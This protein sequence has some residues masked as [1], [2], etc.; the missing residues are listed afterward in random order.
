MRSAL[1]NRGKHSNVVVT[2]IAR[3][4]VAFLWA[5][6]QEVPIPARPESRSSRVWAEARPRFGATLDGV[7]RRPRP[8]LVPRTRQALD[9]VTPARYVNRTV[10]I[11]PYTT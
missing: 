11:P 2:A 6:A 1:S 9:G 4:L 3:E 5:I 10:R 7:Q 8:T